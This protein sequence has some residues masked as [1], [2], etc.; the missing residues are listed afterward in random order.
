M[1]FLEHRREVEPTETLTFGRAGD[2]VIDE[3][4]RELHRVQGTIS[5]TNGQWLIENNGRSAALIVTDLDGASYVR[6][7]AG[8]TLPIPFKNNA[9]TFSAGRSNYRLQIEHPS[10]P[11]PRSAS[12]IASSVADRTLTTGALV[13]NDEQF[14]LMVALSERRLI[15]PIT[16]AD[17]PSNREVAKRLGWSLTKVNRKL[18]HLCIKLDKAG[19]GGL[20]G[21]IDNV[22]VE[23][24]LALADFAVERGIVTEASLTALP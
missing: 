13:F 7:A 11:G 21:S 3:T 23:R 5:A 16:A 20:R 12:V 8:A 19:V 9:V 18:D 4:N 2:V 1:S 14:Q 22:A 6:I 10:H 24:R 17:L 15:G